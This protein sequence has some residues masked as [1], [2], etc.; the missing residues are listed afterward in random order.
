MDYKQYQQLYQQL[1]TDAGLQSVE[2][3]IGEKEKVL[4]QI[5]EFLGK[6][7]TV[8]PKDKNPSTPI[9]ELSVKEIYRRTL[10]SS[11]DVIN[12]VSDLISQ[13]NYMSQTTYRRKLF[14]V[15]TKPERRLYMGVWLVFLSF[16]L[17]FVDS[18]A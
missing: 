7:P 5:N 14:E 2:N 4:K 12:E 18:A 11:I 13:K 10:Q 6:Y 16:V 3:T 9:F 1:L 8:V 15:F 17:Y